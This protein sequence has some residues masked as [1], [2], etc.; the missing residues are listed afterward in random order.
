M[1]RRVGRI[2]QPAARSYSA[3]DPAEELALMETESST[4]RRY[5]KLNTAWNLAGFKGVNSARLAHSNV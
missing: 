2:E 4:A 3:D 5:G 1:I